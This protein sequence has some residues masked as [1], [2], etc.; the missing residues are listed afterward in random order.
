MSDTSHT[1]KFDEQQI[2]DGVFTK[3]FVDYI[4]YSVSVYKTILA[5]LFRF[6]TTRSVRALLLKGADPNIR[7]QD[8]R[9]PVDFLAD[10]DS[11]IPNV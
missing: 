5:L 9:L 4:V 10:F 2:N 3:I 6:L 1:L 11:Y 7:D 8:D